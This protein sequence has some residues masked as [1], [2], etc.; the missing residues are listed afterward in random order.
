MSS[1]RIRT[2]DAA[3]SPSRRRLLTAAAVA[4]VLVGAGA[5]AAQAE[6]GHH[7]GHA[8]LQPVPT[9]N[10]D[11]QGVADVLS[12]SGTVN[13]GAVYKVGLPRRDLHVTSYGVTIKPG[14]SL[15]GYAVFAR[16]QDGRTLMMGDL[17]VTEGE[18]QRATDALHAGGLEQT[19]IHKHLLAHEPAIWWTHFHGMAE[20][21]AVLARA[22][23]SALDTT[24]IP[25]AVPAGPPP[26]L[27]LDTVGI[28]DA[29][30][31][32]GVNDGGIYKF[33]F[34]RC[35]TVTEHGRILPPA[36][37]VTT[38]LNF[39]PLGG[40]RA[41][42]NGDFCMTADEVQDVLTAL[43]HGGINVV[44]LHNHGLMDEPRLFYCHFWAVEDAVVL[45][46]ALRAAVDATNTTPA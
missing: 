10:A 35:E 25:P 27:D 8:A 1:K 38:A 14:L 24:A 9:T 40:G 21:P 43:R 7:G 42:I 23:K 22:L 44:E 6:P 3:A 36:M 28:D 34:K 33:T 46:R 32:K 19:A 45:A 18:L 2:G 30:D 31:A 37:G 39:Q 5:A 11:W 41:A 12:R 20:D 4:P 29:L 26:A 13:G 17:V 15:G 16:Y